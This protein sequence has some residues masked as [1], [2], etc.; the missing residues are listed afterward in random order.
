VK[1]SKSLILSFVF[2]LEVCGVTFGQSYTGFV[3]GNYAGAS[4]IIHQPASIADNAYPWDFVL[5][6]IN[7]FSDNNYGK[8]KR[9]RAFMNFNFS[10]ITSELI[11][12]KETKY[13]LLNLEATGP[14]IMVRLKNARAVGFTSRVRTYINADGLTGDLATIIAD[15]FNNPSLFDLNFANQQYYLKLNSWQE[16]GITYAQVLRHTPYQKIKAGVTAKLLIENG[17]VQVDFI[18]GNLQNVGD[19]LLLIPEFSLEY[20]YS[21]KFQ[22][23]LDGNFSFFKGKKGFGMDLGLEYEV[24]DGIRGS[25]PSSTKIIDDFNRQTNTVPKYKYKLGFSLLDIGRL[26]YNYGTYSGEASVVS[27][28]TDVIDLNLLKG[29]YSDPNALSDSLSN[30][31]NLS[32]KSGNYTMGLPTAFQANIDYRIRENLYI[33]AN[34]YVNLAFLKW[35]DYNVHDISNLTITPRWENNWLGF[36][37]PFYTN[38]KGQ[39]NMGL[40]THIGPL[41]FGVHDILPFLVRKESTSVGAYFMLKTFIPNKKKKSR[42][43]C[44]PSGWERKKK[45]TA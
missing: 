2:F 10:D 34:T 8:V 21:E 12:D 4:G 15:G 35:S 38:I 25:T 17:G 37:V 26:K 44:G 16:Y 23:I 43:K 45:K 32:T 24:Y 27:D 30:M 9:S 28:G 3:S 20:G 36:Y 18:T 41:V 39:F 1:E 22:N 14:S 42:F 31:V 13:G 40:A 5:V 6:G 29:T 11:R 7:A 33:N 19:K